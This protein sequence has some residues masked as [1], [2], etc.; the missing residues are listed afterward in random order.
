MSTEGTG[1]KKVI[2]QQV[3]KVFPQAVGNGKDYLP[4]VYQHSESLNYE[5]DTNRLIVFLPGHGLNP[6]DRVRL[7]GRKRNTKS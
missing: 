3:E 5:A 1:H 4:D 6:G 2:A 7:M